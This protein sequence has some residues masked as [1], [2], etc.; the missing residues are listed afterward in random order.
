MIFVQKQRQCPQGVNAM[1]TNSVLPVTNPGA[2]VSDSGVPQH[3]EL[4]LKFFERAV[5]RQEGE[6]GAFFRDF[7][8]ATAALLAFQFVIFFRFIDLDERRVAV[9]TTIQHFHADQASLD[10]VHAQLASLRETLR[11]GSER[12]SKRLRDT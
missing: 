6:R 7:K 8:L 9:E 12:M 4:I 2:K 3:K 1:S 11:L 10:E 5:E